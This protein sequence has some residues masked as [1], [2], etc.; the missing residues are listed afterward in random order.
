MNLNPELRNLE[1]RDPAT[2]PQNLKLKTNTPN[3]NLKV[4]VSLNGGQQFSAEAIDIFTFFTQPVFT[5]HTLCPQLY[6]LCPQL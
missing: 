4:A 5:L 3:P 1:S 6:T 2:R